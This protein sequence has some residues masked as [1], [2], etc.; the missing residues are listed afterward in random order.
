MKLI[1]HVHIAVWCVIFWMEFL[2]LQQSY[3]TNWV[4]IWQ[5][6]TDFVAVILLLSIKSQ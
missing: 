1:G 4:D 2:V 3:S 5:L 6:S